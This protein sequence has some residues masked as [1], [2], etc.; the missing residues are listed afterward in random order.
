MVTTETK[1]ATTK[2][3]NS[4][5]LIKEIIAFPQSNFAN[6]IPLRLWN[7]VFRINS[8]FQVQFYFNKYNFSIS[9]IYRSA[10]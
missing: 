5:K 8:H 7:F 2:H 6:Q 4:L 3:V 1:T 10:I 9:I